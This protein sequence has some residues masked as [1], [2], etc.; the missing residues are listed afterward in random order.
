MSQ[1]SRSVSNSGSQV[2]TIDELKQTPL[3]QSSTISKG[4]SHNMTSIRSL[5][6]SPPTD[7]VGTPPPQAQ[8]L[9]YVAHTN[10]NKS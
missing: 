7:R 6:N 8:D 2:V 4:P 10:N 9:S 3:H 5:M 1:T